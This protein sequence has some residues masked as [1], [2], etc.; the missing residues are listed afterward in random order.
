MKRLILISVLLFTTALFSQSLEGS[1]KMIEENGV[2]VTDKEII[3]IYQ[4]NYFAEGARQA[5]TNQ[6]LWALGGEYTTDDYSAT[7]DFNTRSPEMVGEL[8]DPKLTFVSEDKIRI[9]NV[10]GVEVWERISGNE[11]DLTGNWIITGIQRD[12]KI[13]KMKPGDRRTIKILGGDRFQWVA[14]NSD[15]REFFGSGGGTYSAENG[16]YIENIDFFSRD[17][18]R[19]GAS[20]DFEFELKDGEWHHSGK[21]SKGK[22]I[23]E[24]WSP[25]AK[26][27]SK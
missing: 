19:V 6:F 16:K 24:I 17:N 14:F 18:S 13:R 26:A 9:N 10:T 20:L 4:N 7:H 3:R 1:W 23:Y 15:T 21:S 5:D 11:N 8:V 22:P 2:P 25:Y 27:Y 12:G